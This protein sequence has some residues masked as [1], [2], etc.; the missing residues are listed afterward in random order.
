MDS[1]R[2]VVYYCKNSYSFCS[3]IRFDLTFYRF[4]FLSFF[5]WINFSLFSFSLLCAIFKCPCAGVCHTLSQANTHIHDL[6][7]SHEHNELFMH[8]N[9]SRPPAT[10]TINSAPISMCRK[11][12]RL[13]RMAV[14]NL[15]YCFSSNVFCCRWMNC[16]RSQIT[17]SWTFEWTVH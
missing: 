9:K 3:T 5:F 15:K 8:L 2:Y 11:P 17:N 6:S 16:L 4:L 1:L 12:R 7:L 10:I 14:K 13:H